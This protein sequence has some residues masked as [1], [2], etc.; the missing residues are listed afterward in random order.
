MRIGLKTYSL[1][2]PPTAIDTMNLYK[3][4]IMSP[5]RTA[6]KMVLDSD[7]LYKIIGE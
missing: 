7:T 6:M 4:G 3:Y 2:M 1:D 5:F